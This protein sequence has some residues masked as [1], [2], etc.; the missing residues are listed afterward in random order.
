[1]IGRLSPGI[2]IAEYLSVVTGMLGE[3]APYL[4]VNSFPAS[5]VLTEKHVARKCGDNSSCFLENVSTVVQQQFKERK[6]QRNWMLVTG[7][8]TCLFSLILMFQDIDADGIV[9]MQLYTD[10]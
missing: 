7:R 9:M 2:S 8:Y 3:W 6:V 10:R 4:L 1:M 5:C